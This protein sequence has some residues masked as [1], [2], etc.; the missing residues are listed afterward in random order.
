[1]TE[2]EKAA[3][4][5][6]VNHRWAAPPKRAWVKEVELAFLSGCTWA[7]SRRQQLNTLSIQ[8][9]AYC[10]KCDAGEITLY[11]RSDIC[12]KCEEE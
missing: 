7:E 2:A 6:A 12:A 1:M 8:G 4:K 3:R 9:S 11:A 5:Y 10:T